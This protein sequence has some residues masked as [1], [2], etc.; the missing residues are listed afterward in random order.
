MN[1]VSQEISLTVFQNL[2][3]KQ[4]QPPWKHRQI[5]TQEGFPPITLRQVEEDHDPLLYQQSLQLAIL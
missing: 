2:I 5:Q 1:S 4:G 3:R